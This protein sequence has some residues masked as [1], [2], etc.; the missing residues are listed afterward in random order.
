MERLWTENVMCNLCE[1]HEAVYIVM[2]LIG[3]VL[4]AVLQCVLIVIN[5]NVVNMN[6]AFTF[7][8]V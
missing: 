5:V 1:K 6:N 4:L 3:L 7:A 2:S 8:N